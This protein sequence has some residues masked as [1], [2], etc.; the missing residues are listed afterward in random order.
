MGCSS[1]AKAV[2]GATQ[3]LRVI[4]EAQ[5]RGTPAAT[6]CSVSINL[7]DRRAREWAATRTHLQDSI[8]IRRAAG[9][10]RDDHFAKSKAELRSAAS[11]A[12]AEAL[13]RRSTA[14]VGAGTG[15][16]GIDV[17]SVLG[18]SGRSL[19]LLVA[20][21]EGAAAAASA[22]AA[23][24]H[25]ET[26]GQLLVGRR[27]DL[28][29]TTSDGASGSGDGGAAAEPAL[30]HAWTVCRA[31]KMVEWG[32]SETALE[33]A[34]TTVA[35]AACPL[36]R[37]VVYDL[38]L[39]S[40]SSGGTPRESAALC[41]AEFLTR[42][43][44]WPQD[45]DSDD[46]RDDGRKEAGVPREVRLRYLLTIPDFDSLMGEWSGDV[47]SR[48]RLLAPVDLLSEGARSAG[49]HLGKGSSV[50]GKA[51]LLKAGDAAGGDDAEAAP[52]PTEAT[53]SEGQT[54][55]VRYMGRSRWWRGK[56]KKVR[57]NGTY[58]VQYEDNEVERR[59]KP[60]YIR[61][62]GAEGVLR[63]S[64]TH[65]LTVGLDGRMVLRQLRGTG[66]V[67]VL[68]TQFTTGLA[69]S[70]ALPKPSDSSRRL[71]VAD[72]RGLLQS[73]FLTLHPREA[74]LDGDVVQEL[75]AMDDEHDWGSIARASAS[76]G[77]LGSREVGGPLFG[78]VVV[79]DRPVALGVGAQRPGL[80]TLHVRGVA[81]ALTRATRGFIPRFSNAL[82]TQSAA[83]GDRSGS[84]GGA[85][86]SKGSRS[87]TRTRTGR[88]V[89]KVKYG[90]DVE[91]SGAGDTAL[92]RVLSTRDH[93]EGEVNDVAVAFQK[94][95]APVISLLP[96]PML[97]PQQLEACLNAVVAGRMRLREYL[98]P[99]DVIEGGL[100][101]GDTRHAIQYLVDRRAAAAEAVEA[102][103]AAEG[104]RG[105]AASPVASATSPPPSTSPSLAASQQGTESAG[106]PPGLARG[107]GAESFGD[108]E[109]DAQGHPAKKS[110]R[111]ESSGGAGARARSQTAG[112][113]FAVP[114]KKEPKRNRAAENARRRIRAKLSPMEKLRGDDLREMVEIAY[115]RCSDLWSDLLRFCEAHQHKSAAHADVMRAVAEQ[116][117]AG[118]QPVNIRGAPLRRERKR[119]APLP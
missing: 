15:A 53:Y 37:V 81:A 32:V 2:S 52:S 21:G 87:D 117:G 104:A 94:D 9:A 71:R 93:A 105:A 109:G 95:I 99:P 72:F 102:R 3:Y 46:G 113:R 57:P 25:K 112:E 45:E 66:A 107:S 89:K 27:V 90:N 96:A 103:I 62:A 50:G 68:A 83:G 65:V 75:R 91:A 49:L 58:D 78:H 101:Y 19:V 54:V 73:A 116:H 41:N 82:V 100:F 22:A 48:R 30:K 108:D 84:S 64:A 6:S 39:K 114:D 118:V 31:S 92:S 59:V 85:D 36:R 106:I 51:I 80:D 44:G 29:C 115:R 35:S 69:V 61:K 10:A 97:Q 40:A 86:E 23:R 76:D 1:L 7:W 13:A 17:G 12:L 26:D 11:S 16:G 88:T 33:R 18:G 98:P 70:A 42:N 24:A 55:E 47:H 8:G 38:P 77:A 5:P 14:D 119:T 111:G 43:D 74:L 63:L 28:V 56:I 110:R 67:P 4:W 20:V 34:F 60:V 79:G